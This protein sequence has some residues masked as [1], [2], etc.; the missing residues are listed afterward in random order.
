[1]YGAAVRLPVTI[2]TNTY[3]KMQYLPIQTF[4]FTDVLCC[5]HHDDDGM[6]DRL[7]RISAIVDCLVR[8]LLEE[9]RNEVPNALTKVPG[10][11]R[12]AVSQVPMP[13]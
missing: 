10:C 12:L 2:H 7:D 8:R 5:K 1:M 6:I 9:L 13:Y 11:I 3:H 4:K